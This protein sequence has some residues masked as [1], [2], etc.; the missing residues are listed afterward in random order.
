MTSFE[1]TNSVFNITNQNKSFLISTTAHRNSK[2][3]EEL[4]NRLKFLLE[5]RSEND[6]E[7]HVREVVKRC[8][9]KEIENTGCNLANFGHFKSE[10]LVETKR[11]KCKDLGDMVYRMELNYVKL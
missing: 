6:I 1:A 11:V 8:T 3:G 4:I 10:V 9:R 2:D 5:L 7:L